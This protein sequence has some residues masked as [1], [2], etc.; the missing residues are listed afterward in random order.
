MQSATDKVGP[1]TELAQQYG[2]AVLDTL[3]ANVPRDLRWN[4]LLLMLALALMIFLLRK[5]RGAKGADG[6]ERPCGLAEYLLPRDIYTHV[7]ARVDVWLWVFER[8][9]KPVWALLLLGSLGPYV[10]RSVIGAM[11][12][13]FGAG[14]PQLPAEPDGAFPGLAPHDSGNHDCQDPANRRR[15]IRVKDDRDDVGCARQ[16]ACIHGCPTNAFF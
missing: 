16:S 12:A 5:G 15:S 3:S 8:A 14:L 11:T 9:L 1:F 6:R 13:G 7:S 2:P 4:Y 10:E